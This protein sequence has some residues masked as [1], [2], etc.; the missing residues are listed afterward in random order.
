MPELSSSTYS[1]TDASNNAAAPSGMPEGQ[2]PGSVNNSWRAGMGALKRFWGRINPVYASTGTA[3]GYLLAHSVAL[4]TYSGNE[5]LAFRAHTASAASPTLSVDSLAAIAMKRY[6]TSGKAAL[7]ANEIQSGQPVMG[8]HDGTDFVVLSPIAE[9]TYA[10]PSL[11]RGYLSGLGISNNASDATNDIDIAAG[12]A[13][14]ST[15]AT[16]MKLTSGITKRLDASW[17]VGTNQGGLDAGSIAN[18]TYHMFLIKRLDTGVVDALFST[19]STSPTMPTSY[20]YKRRIGS[21]VRASNAIRT[22]VQSGD[23]FLWKA[24]GILDVNATNPGT[25]AVNR[26]LSVPNGIVVEATVAVTLDM[27]SSTG[28]NVALTSLDQDDATASANNNALAISNTN[29]D[30]SQVSARC[31]VKTD[32]NAQIRSRMGT[33][34]ASDVLRIATIGWDDRRGRDD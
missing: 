8:Y 26:T 16:F 9:T 10:D 13:V 34:G 31:Q 19:H 23:R 15:A 30:D 3:G 6:T 27:I 32:V 1:E 24:D 7:A 4:S 17:A 21:I 5:L 33:S 22:F 18:T 14:D 11:M 29:G 12:V 25:A 28:I 2:T 20:D